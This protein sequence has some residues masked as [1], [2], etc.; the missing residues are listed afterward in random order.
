MWNVV[1]FV[2]FCLLLSVCCTVCHITVHIVYNVIYIIIILIINYNY[3]ELYFLKTYTCTCKMCL[4]DCVHVEQL[5]WL[6]VCN[7]NYM[8]L[9]SYKS[10]E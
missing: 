10:Q 3:S 2:Y 1:F 9:H 7:V 4:V 5:S 6:F 8:Y